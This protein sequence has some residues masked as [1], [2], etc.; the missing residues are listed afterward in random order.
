MDLEVV[1][2]TWKGLSIAKQRTIAVV[3]S[4]VGGQ[5]KAHEGCGCKVGKCNTKS[6]TCFA[7][8]Q[9]CGSSCHSGEM[10]KNCINCKEKEIDL[11]NDP[12]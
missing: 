7:A 4:R 5:G 10:N 8:N 6:Y 1:Y 3:V 12:S 2:Q 9:V 11:E